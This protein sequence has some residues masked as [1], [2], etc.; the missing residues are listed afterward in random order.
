MLSDQSAGVFFNDSTKIV[1]E[2]KGSCFYYYE[3]KA[4]SSS[5]KQDVL[6]KYQFNEFPKELQKK[7]TLLEHFKS[8]LQSSTAQQ[9]A[10]HKHAE[11]ELNDDMKA[12]KPPAGSVYVKKWMRTRHAIM[13]R[14]SNKIVQVNFQD[15]TEILLNSDN[16]LVTYVNKKGERS[17][18]PLSQALDSNN[19]EMT[20][21]L[22]YTKDILTHML[23][24]N[25][26]T[27][28]NAPQPQ[29]PQTAKVQVNPSSMRSGGTAPGNPGNGAPLT[30]AI[31]SRRS[32]LRI[33]S[34]SSLDRRVPQ[35][36][37]ENG[38]MMK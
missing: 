1:S 37:S 3:R 12:L 6:T 20:K 15:H 38:G 36:V 34:A 32:E 23:N 18:M 17:I 29:A 9:S 2:D 28:A 26:P 13:F 5:E 25:G 21:R 24:N 14:L 33:A 27:S 11:M 8:Y 22:K 35:Y 7:V 16:R 30:A 31:G 19:Q 4:I 10:S